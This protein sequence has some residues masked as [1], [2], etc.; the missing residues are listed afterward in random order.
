MKPRTVIF[1]TDAWKALTN[2][3][4]LASARLHTI[5]PELIERY[6][7][8]CRNSDPPFMAG[9]INNHL[10]ALRRGLHLAVEWRVLHKVPK[11]TLLPSSEERNRKFII[12]EDTL[13]DILNE[14]RDD[15]GGLMFSLLV[16]VLVD[17]GLRLSEALNLTWDDV[18]FT[19]KDNAARGYIHVTASKSDAGVRFVPLTGRARGCLAECK[20]R[21]KCEFVFTAIKGKRKLSAKWSSEQFRRIREKLGLP[22][23][24]IHSCRHT[25]LTRLGEAG[26]DAYSIQRLAG[27]S[28]VTISQKYIHPT[29]E[30]LENVIGMLEAKE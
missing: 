10:R 9:S 23:A 8:H 14:A 1:Y 5:D 24:V 13:T 6:I 29:P 17:T 3:R 21:S 25:F 19:P 20:K 27:H 4:P 26:A 15:D 18:S 12:S 7:Q 16:M 30:R 28:S 2:F 11:I 22:W